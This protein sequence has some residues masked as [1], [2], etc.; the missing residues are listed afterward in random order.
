MLDLYANVYSQPSGWILLGLILLIVWES[1]WKAIALWFSAKN[2]QKGWFIVLLIFNTIGL[3]P[4]IYLIW[5]KP[6]TEKENA[7]AQELEI[8]E[9]PKKT[10]KKIIGVTKKPAKKKK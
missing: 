5:F 4:I 9:E 8:S 6:K 10:H 7:P 3:L 1:V 2:Q